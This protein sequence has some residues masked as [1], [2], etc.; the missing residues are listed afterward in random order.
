MIKRIIRIFKKEYKS[1]NTIELSKNNLLQNYRYLSSVN[2]KIKIA[3]VV[4]GNAYGHGILEISKI[5]DEVNPPF[6]CVDSLYEAYELL[7][8]GI[9]TQVLIMGYTDPQNFKFKKLPFCYAVF[10]KEILKT[11]NK[12]QTGCKIHIFVDTGMNREGVSLKNLPTFLK[13]LK[14]YPNLKIEGLMSHLASSDNKNDL[15]NK[16]QIKNFKKALEICKRNSVNPKW[17]HLANSDGLTNFTKELSFTNVARIGLSSYGV[18]SNQ[19]LKPVLSLKSKI[20]QV[21]QLKKGDKVGYSGTYMARK[22]KTLGVLP[23]GYFDGVDR[24]LSNK[25]YVG[26]EKVFCPIVGKVSMN[27]TTIDISKVKNPF[28]GQSVVVY[29]DNPRAKNCIKSAAKIC[30]TVPTNILSL[31]NASTKRIII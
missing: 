5:L 13:E 8:T 20:I 4:K 17:I 11:L 16:L 3:P 27:I 14:S 9:N 30:R 22:E 28:V 19:N 10:N 1:L 25:G 6:F 24:R 21:K 18:S 12:Y 23:I 29:S 31:L 7:K 15:L 2:K 26:M